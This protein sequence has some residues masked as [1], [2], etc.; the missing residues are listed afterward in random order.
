MSVEPP[1][2]NDSLSSDVMKRAKCAPP[3]TQMLAHY[4]SVLAK[5]GV[6]ADHDE[7][8]DCIDFMSVS[9]DSNRFPLKI[10]TAKV[11]YCV[12]C[13]ERECIVPATQAVG[14]VPP[15]VDAHEWCRLHARVEGARKGGWKGLGNFLR[16]V[17]RKKATTFLCGGCTHACGSTLRPGRVWVYTAVGGQQRVRQSH[18]LAR[19]LGPCFAAN[20]GP[21]DRDCFRVVHWRRCR[22]L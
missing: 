9:K 20:N 2:L 18:T 11:P 13:F 4:S 10:L 1:L 8:L 17:S 3:V 21:E 22:R 19:L 14:Q 7:E 15:G 12:Y 5:L 16:V 6:K